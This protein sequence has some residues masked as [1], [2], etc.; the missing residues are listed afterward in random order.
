ME[1]LLLESLAKPLTFTTEARFH[2]YLVF[3]SAS[4]GYFLTKGP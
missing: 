1:E 4:S 3:I 2:Y